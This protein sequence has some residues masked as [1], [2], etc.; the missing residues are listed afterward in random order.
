MRVA[1]KRRPRQ[2]HPALCVVA[3]CRS[4]VAAATVPEPDRRPLTLAAVA[5][6]V[7]SSY[8]VTSYQHV[9]Y[10]AQGLEGAADVVAAYARQVQAE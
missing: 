1:D 7:A 5:E 8:P 4:L 10:V 3:V 2:V 9:Y 6:V